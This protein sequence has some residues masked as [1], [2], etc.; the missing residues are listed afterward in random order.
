MHEV[1]TY[2]VCPNYKTVFHIL[3]HWEFSADA[4]VTAEKVWDIYTMND[5]RPPM[6]KYSKGTDGRLIAKP[7]IIPNDRSMSRV[8]TLH[9]HRFQRVADCPIPFPWPDIFFQV[10]PNDDLK[11]LTSAGLL[12]TFS[13]DHLISHVVVGQRLSSCSTMSNHRQIYAQTDSTNRMGDSDFLQG[14]T[15]EQALRAVSLGRQ[16]VGVKAK[17]GTVLG[18]KLKP[19]SLFDKCGTNLKVQEIAPHLGCACSKLGTDYHIL[20]KSLHK[21]VINYRLRFRVEMPTREVVKSATSTMQEFTQRGAV[22]RL[23]T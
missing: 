9:D 2:L 5:I 1:T 8:V 7:L 15:L 4:Y 16:S 11:V 12:P 22:R 3:Q 14:G 17:Y 19:N 10:S 20:L 23:P 6:E 18:L 13:S 21:K